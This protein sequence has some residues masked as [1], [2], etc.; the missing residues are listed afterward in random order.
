MRNGSQW[1][2]TVCND[3]A[4]ILKEHEKRNGAPPDATLRALL[5]T[6]SQY[7]APIKI[8]FR[9][10]ALAG[11]SGSADEDPDAINMTQ[12]LNF[13]K[14]VRLLDGKKSAASDFDR[15]Y[16]RAIRSV[17]S[18]KGDLGSVVAAA[19]AEG[20][21][22]AEDAAQIAAKLDIGSVVSAKKMAKTMKKQAE[23][24]GKARATM[25]QVRC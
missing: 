6:I 22:N 21:G 24:K 18:G 7:S 4:D 11:A 16:K 10:Y 2:L 1:N 15:L 25:A 20:G 8:A 12:F 3:I 9:Y 17:P 19:V 5:E 13:C 23:K 14:G